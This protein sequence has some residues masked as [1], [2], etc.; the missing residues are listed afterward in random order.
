MSVGV[1][2]T[3]TDTFIEHTEPSS[4]VAYHR[5]DS[6]Q[7]GEHCAHQR[8][9]LERLCRYVARAPLALERLSVT[10][11]GKLR[12]ARKHPYANGATHFLFEPRDLLARLAALVPRPR[13]NLTRY[14]GVFAPNS[15]LRARLVS[16]KHHPF[17]HLWP[18][19][20]WLVSFPTNIEPQ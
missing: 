8:N 1:G 11:E 9:K 16:A 3:S 2:N 5:T 10:D 14:H 6:P 4:D 13:L 17:V 18:Q 15:K 19:N 7:F 12:Y 20:I